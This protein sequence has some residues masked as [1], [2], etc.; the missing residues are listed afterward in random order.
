MQGETPL[1]AVSRSPVKQAGGNAGTCR[2]VGCP[3]SY[4]F[5]MERSGGSRPTTLLKHT[6]GDDRPGVMGGVPRKRENLRHVRARVNGDLVGTHLNPCPSERRNVSVWM[7]WYVCLYVLI[8]IESANRD[9]SAR[10]WLSMELIVRVGMRD[11][12]MV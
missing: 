7:W 10:S 9:K 1:P 8:W 4:F 11:G 6:R 12:W 3:T 5:V 2:E